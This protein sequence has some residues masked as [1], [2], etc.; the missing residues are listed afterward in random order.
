[1]VSYNVGHSVGRK[2]YKAMVCVKRSQHD[3]G[4]AASLELQQR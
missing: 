4:G 3:S 1:M 2:N